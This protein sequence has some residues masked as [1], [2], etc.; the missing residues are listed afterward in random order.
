MGVSEPSLHRESTDSLIDAARMHHPALA[1]SREPI[2]NR[3]G[4]ARP[5]L[6][7]LPFAPRDNNYYKMVSQ[8]WEVVGDF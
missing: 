6:T 8:I 7:C 1:T 4:F 5:V 2:I 3:R